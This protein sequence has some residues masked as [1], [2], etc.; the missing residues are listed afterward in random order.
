[1]LVLADERGRNL[2]TVQQR[3]RN[4]VGAADDVAIC[5]NEAVRREDEA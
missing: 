3:N 1:V 5:Q 2:A 4:P